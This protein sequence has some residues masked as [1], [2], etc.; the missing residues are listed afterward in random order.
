MKTR[1]GFVSNSSSSSFV[2]DVCGED[3]SGMD[4]GLSGAEMFECVVGHV[5]CDSH[6]VDTQADFDDLSFEEKRKYCLARADGES[7]KETIK[8]AE[9]EEELDDVYS[10]EIQC[11]ERYDTPAENCP[12]CTLSKP[13]DLQVIEFLL[14]EVK[15]T[16]EKVVEQMQ[17]RF[18]N[19]AEMEKE[20]DGL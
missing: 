5:V 18:K 14:S 19:Y 10:D 8:N 7:T 3:A 6:A 17:K 15:S 1:R 11:E 20:L 2:C 12:C 4:M 13:T 9:H 16:R